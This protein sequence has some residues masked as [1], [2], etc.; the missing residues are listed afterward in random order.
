M[1]QIT[2]SF[3]ENLGFSPPKCPK[4]LDDKQQCR[5]EKAGMTTSNLASNQ[6]EVVSSLS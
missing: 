4:L 1:L 3:P 2:P 5:G 6:G